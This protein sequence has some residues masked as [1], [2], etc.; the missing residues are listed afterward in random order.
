MAIGKLKYDLGGDMEFN[1]IIGYL[2]TDES[3]NQ[4]F[5]STPETLYHTDRPARWKQLTNEARLVMGGNG[6][7][8]F[9]LGG[10]QW[11]SKYTINLKNYIGFAGAPLLTSAQTVT[12]TTKSW[13]GYFEGDYKITDKLKLTLGG[14]Y[15]HDT[16]TTQVNDGTIYI[17]GTLEEKD[18]ILVLPPSAAAGNIVMPAPIKASWSKFTPKVSLSYNWTDEVMTYEIGRAHV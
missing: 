10:Y 16:K 14:R 5:D 13:A 17:Y 1:Y 3:I 12:Q 18:P 9:V 7:L 8:T 15:T 11:Y 6:P 4:D 2:K